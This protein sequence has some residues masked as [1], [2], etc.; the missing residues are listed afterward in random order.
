MRYPALT[1]IRLRKK[2]L[3]CGRQPPW[4]IAIHPTSGTNVQLTP[5][6]P[7]FNNG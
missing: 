7:H 4:E 6:I 5:G 1:Q 2:F 3:D